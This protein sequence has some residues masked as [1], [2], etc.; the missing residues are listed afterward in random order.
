LSRHAES[1]VEPAD[2]EG[3]GT[4]KLEPQ[5]HLISQPLAVLGVR[6]AGKSCLV[7]KITEGLCEVGQPFIVIDREGEYWTLRERYPVLVAA[8]GKP[9]GRP[10][11][12]RAD[13]E[14]SSSSLWRT[15]LQGGR[16]GILPSP[17]LEECN[18]VRNI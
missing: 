14:L 15:S 17:R 16:E 8:V 3:D 2:I 5:E 13:I 18:H 4:L 10:R 7:G 6:Y 9:S 12:Y 11:G 1:F